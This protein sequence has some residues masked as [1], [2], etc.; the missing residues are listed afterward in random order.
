MEYPGSDEQIPTDDLIERQLRLWNARRRAAQEKLKEESNSC[1]RFLTIAR[2]EGSLGNEIAQELSRRLGWHVF[3]KEI[4]TYIA[5]NNHVRESLIRQLD[6]KS[7]S[8]IED[9]ISRFLRMPEYA[10][11]GVEEYRE[12][13]LKTLIC[14]A[15]HG[16]AIL[17]GRG[18]NFALR[19][20]KRGLFIRITASSEV[21]IQR[22]SKS[23]K[24]SP[25]E[26]RRLMQADDEERREFIR[27]H[28][29]KDFDDMRFYD[30][31]FNTD[32]LSIEQVVMS[33]LPAIQGPT[34]E[35]TEGLSPS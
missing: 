8:L 27:Q 13:L 24:V 23:W 19:D 11:F 22:L 2:D 5:E 6:Q 28:Y 17:V 21:R 20:D 14:V 16:S 18:A 15:A 4:V 7:Q 30:L 12:A 32:R 9:A 25:E 29:R 31:I 3:D 35:E 33:I 34:S 10:S 1:I 26:A